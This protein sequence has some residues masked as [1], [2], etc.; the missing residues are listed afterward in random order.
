MHFIAF[1]DGSP[2]GTIEE[3]FV[4]MKNQEKDQS[5]FSAEFRPFM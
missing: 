2:A 3:C 1:P 4:N 5:G